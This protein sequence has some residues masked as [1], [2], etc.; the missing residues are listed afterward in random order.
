MVRLLTGM[1]EYIWFNFS[2]CGVNRVWNQRQIL[3]QPEM[4][5]GSRRG[6]CFSWMVTGNGDRIIIA[7]W[8]KTKYGVTSCEG[9]VLIIIN[10]D[11]DFDI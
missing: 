5:T 3:F 1:A 7:D 9:H 10:L 8:K 4:L 11:K 6:K 2:N